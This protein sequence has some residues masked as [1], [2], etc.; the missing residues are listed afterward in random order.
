MSRFVVEVEFTEHWHDQVPAQVKT[1]I[2]CSP[3]LR[4]RS[5]ETGSL[6]SIVDEVHNLRDRIDG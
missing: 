3:Y 4:V 6:Q 2:E 5:V 1:L